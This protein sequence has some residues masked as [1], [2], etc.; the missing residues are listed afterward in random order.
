MIGIYKIENKTNGKVYIGQSK[1]IMQRWSIHEQMLLKNEHHSKKLQK[2]FNNS[3]NGL[4]DFSFEILEI[5]EAKDLNEKEKSYIKNFDSINKGYNVAGSI[6]NCKKEILFSYENFTKMCQTLKPQHIPIYMHFLYITDNDNNF[7]L[8]QLQLAG[9]LGVSPITISKTLKML[10][11][12]NI[13]KKIG[14]KG[15]NNVYHLLF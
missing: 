14:K 5:C 7:T 3:L 8:N 13:I 10:E 4:Q 15:L 6:E 11:E 12:N 2:D 9:I 1:N